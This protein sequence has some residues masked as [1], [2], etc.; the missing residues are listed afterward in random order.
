[1]HDIHIFVS[2]TFSDMHRERDLLHQVAGLTNRDLFDRGYQIVLHDLRSGVDTAGAED[3]QEIERR[4]LKECFDVI[5]ECSIFVLLLGDRYG[6]VFDDLTVPCQ[7]MPDQKLEGKSVTH[8]EVE[9]G[10][11]NI[12]RANFLFFDRR[13]LGELSEV[14]DKYCDSSAGMLKNRRLKDD[15]YKEGYLVS[16]YHAWMEDGVFVIDEYVF[17]KHMQGY[18]FE[19]VSEYI[20]HQTSDG[21][22]E[23]WAVEIPDSEELGTELA[24]VV[25]RKVNCY[26]E[27]FRETAK[28]L[29]LLRIQNLL[30]KEDFDRIRHRGNNGQAILEYRRSLIERL[31][32]DFIG[33]LRSL[34]RSISG[35]T[36]N[37]EDFFGFLQI[38]ACA[39]ETAL[40]QMG[41]IS[42]H[43]MLQ[44]MGS[45]QFSLDQTY[46]EWLNWRYENSGIYRQQLPLQRAL[47]YFLEN[48]ILLTHSENGY[49][50]KDRN[51][52]AYLSEAAPDTVKERIWEY[53]ASVFWYLPDPACAWDDLLRTE[54]FHL[55]LSCLEY[56]RLD[57]RFVDELLDYVKRINNREAIWG[58]LEKFLSW[59]VEYSAE[60]AYIL[61]VMKLYDYLSVSEDDEESNECYQAFVVPLYQRIHNQIYEKNRGN[62]SVA[63]QYLLWYLYEEFEIELNDPPESVLLPHQTEKMWILND[64][65][66]SLFCNHDLSDD[67]QWD[68]YCTMVNVLDAYLDQ[69]DQLIRV[70]RIYLVQG[71]PSWGCLYQNLGLMALSEV[72]PK[73]SLLKILAGVLPIHVDGN[74]ACSAIK[75]GSSNLAEV[76]H[77]LGDDA[78]CISVL[79]ILYDVVC[80]ET[81][82][83]RCEWSYWAELIA[84]NLIDAL[85]STS[86]D[87]VV[88]KIACIQ[89]EI[90][91]F[92]L[93]YESVFEK[94]NAV[95]K[96][97]EEMR[98]EWLEQLG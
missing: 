66:F 24:Q 26:P 41:G 16:D 1:M 31:P 38:L 10:I 13:F 84:C 60:E 86:T 95:Q 8:L 39:Q 37:T 70:L 75:G 87:T 29:L 55:C 78:L 62:L 2:S 48:N 47:A 92:S 61:F 50:F 97:V 11:R 80:A 7:Y 30:H 83:R 35:V 68:A 71:R 79:H 49:L 82:L 5:K 63:Q 81:R 74:Y 96:E 17:L 12:N 91:V 9:Y 53:I 25:N 85:Y 14:P 52:S 59:M 67:E 32:N 69:L 22:G 3:E 54:R 88:T 94:D 45:Q 33:L 64:A 36:D 65:V 58:R 98:A 28:E 19:M 6:S 18:L 89:D 57:S 90:Y 15:L 20:K 43:E 51:V 76:A 46:D 72:L 4:I 42:I 34:C 23:E 40:A 44:L 73:E 56:V 77:A 27:T 21:H 93:D